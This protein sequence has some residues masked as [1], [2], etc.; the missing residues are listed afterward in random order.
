MDYG[1]KVNIIHN[2]HKNYEDAGKRLYERYIKACETTALVDA[3]VIHIIKLFADSDPC[4]ILH[5][6]MVAV[7]SSAVYHFTNKKDCDFE[8]SNYYYEFI[9]F[10]YNLKNEESDTAEDS[11]EYNVIEYA[12][13][14]D[15][16]N[17]MACILN[18]DPVH[19]K[20]LKE[21]YQKD[22]YNGLPSNVVI[23]PFMV[24][25]IYDALVENDK[26]F[27]ARFTTYSN[28]RFVMEAAH[29]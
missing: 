19:V 2:I 24:G 9:D 28:T 4:E 16:Y 20:A 5:D 13:A 1:V 17:D 25:A 29:G 11:P 22:I 26:G 8:S 12:K 21:K 23:S 14:A 18:T 15:S 7:C 6:L 10:K 3:S 27:M